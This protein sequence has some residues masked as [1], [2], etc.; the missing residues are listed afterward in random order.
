MG[1]FGRGRARPDDGTRSRVE[2]WIREAGEFGPDV[3]LKLN[4]IVCADPAC[5]GIETV[6]LVMRPGTRTQALKIGKP[7]AE[8]TAED[9]A[10]ALLPPS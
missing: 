2:A 10:A 7:M 6:V 1:W 5:P 9:V 4:E 3:V 8:I